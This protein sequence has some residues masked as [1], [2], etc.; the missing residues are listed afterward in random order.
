MHPTKFMR[1]I[2]LSGSRCEP[3]S[4]RARKGLLPGRQRCSI[5]RNIDRKNGVS[6]YSTV[7]Q[8]CWYKE[9]LTQAHC[10]SVTPPPFTWHQP[11]ATM[12]HNAL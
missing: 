8:P 5:Y 4:S 7:S 10:L 12:R 1:E 9:P 11:S 2:S 3:K 6:P